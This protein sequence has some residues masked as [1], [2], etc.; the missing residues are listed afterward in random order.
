MNHLE[1]TVRDV[2]AAD[3]PGLLPWLSPLANRGCPPATGPGNSEAPLAERWLLAEVAGRPLAT[4]RLRPAIGLDADRAWYHLGCVVH[5]SAVLGL[6]N[7]QPRLL[8]GNDLCG[9]A[10]L[11]DIAWD[12]GAS[13]LA[14]QAALGVLVLAALNALA[15][16]VPAGQAD[17]VGAGWAASHRRRVLVELP[18]LPPPGPGADP[19]FWA[20]LGRAF[21]RTPPRAAAARL[22]PAWHGPVAALLPRQPVY[23]SFLSAEAQA[24]AGQADPAAAPLLNAL[25]AA[26]FRAGEHITVHDG[27]PVWER[28]LNA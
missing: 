23:L 8:L 27:G 1:T 21:C 4:L 20:G 15:L 18:G 16:A 5:A 3:V 17:A 22:G 19:P 24:A 11:A 25:Q 26:G 7:R 9:A 10:E 28:E 6:F 13:P 2:Q 14:V 12:R